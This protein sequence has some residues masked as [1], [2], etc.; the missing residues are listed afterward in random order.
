MKFHDILEIK[1]SKLVADLV[2]LFLSVCFASVKFIQDIV[3][4]NHKEMSDEC[5]SFQDLDP[6]GVYF[7][8]AWKCWHDL[9]W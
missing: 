3:F 7:Y 5:H 2:Q 1:Q 8:S 4:F 9:R 6:N